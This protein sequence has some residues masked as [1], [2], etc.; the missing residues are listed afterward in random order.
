[1]LLFVRSFSKQAWQLRGQFHNISIEILWK[2]P[3][4]SSRALA[5]LGY[6]SNIV[7]T[8]CVKNNQTTRKADTLTENLLLLEH[9]AQRAEHILPKYTA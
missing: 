8:R 2:N 5:R 4:T 6:I 1:L 9:Q 3:N 7:R